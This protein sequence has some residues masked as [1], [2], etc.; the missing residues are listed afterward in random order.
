MLPGRGGMSHSLS[1]VQL[2][3]SGEMRARVWE[4]P[5]GQV[6]AEFNTMTHLM[7]PMANPPPCQVDETVGK[8]T[9]HTPRTARHRSSGALDAFQVGDKS[10]TK[11][12]CVCVMY[13]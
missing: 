4:Q 10:L 5:A 2:A 7:L 12:N 9:A 8:I 13:I 6:L 11:Y 1:V 3:A